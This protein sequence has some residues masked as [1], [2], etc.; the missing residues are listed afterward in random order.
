M[1]EVYLQ[2]KKI[3]KNKLYLFKSGSFY[4]FLDED[5]TYINNYM[6]LKQTKHNN[7][8]NKCGFP[9]TSIETYKKIFKNINLNYKIIDNYKNINNINIKIINKINNINLEKI[10]YKEAF[11]F[12]KEIKKEMEV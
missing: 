5:A 10:S 9:I 6:V 11:N 12:L 4:I 7:I 2:L 8:C 1:Y 3:D